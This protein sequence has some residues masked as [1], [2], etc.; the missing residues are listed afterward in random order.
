[1]GWKKAFETAAFVEIIPGP[2]KEFV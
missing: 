2:V 1:V